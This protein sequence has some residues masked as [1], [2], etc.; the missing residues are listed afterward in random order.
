MRNTDMVPRE[1]IETP[2]RA[3]GLPAVVR[4]AF[5]LMWAVDASFKW[6]P[7]FRH[8][9]V[10]YLMTDGQPAWERRYIESWRSVLGHDPQ[11]FAVVLALAESAIALSLLLGW[12]VRTTC[13]AGAVLS[14]AIWSS[15]E[16]FGG[17]YGPGSTDV[18][19]SI[20][21][22]LVFALLWWSDAGTRFGLDG[23]LRTRTAPPLR[24]RVLAG[25]VTACSA[26]LIVGAVSVSWGTVP[27][28]GDTTMGGS[29]STSDGGQMQMSPGGQSA[30]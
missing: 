15:A 5:G 1:T 11:L 8:G 4:V 17:P 24:V 25:A 22:V 28:S 9:L 21:Y 13:I 12:R 7:A 27:S 23:W 30:H 20:A 2:A 14:L 29:M 19:A 10:G 26:L 18:G 16:G 3:V 6:A